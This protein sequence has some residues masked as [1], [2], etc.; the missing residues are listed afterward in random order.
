MQATYS[1]RTSRTCHLGRVHLLHHLTI[2]SNGAPTGLFLFCSMMGCIPR[3]KQSSLPMVM[4]HC[5]LCVMKFKII[6]PDNKAKYT[7][8]KELGAG[9]F[10]TALLCR[11]HD[12]ALHQGG[13]YVVLKGSDLTKTF[14]AEA[15]Q[16][17]VDTEVQV[18]FL[19]E[20]ADR[21]NGGQWTSDGDEWSL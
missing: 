15:D 20:G 14:R 18:S 3:V 2:R 13:K 7:S 4:V 12:P 10:G 17:A 19:E 9:A 16:K 1:S 8:V 11:A 21:C 6:N 5:R